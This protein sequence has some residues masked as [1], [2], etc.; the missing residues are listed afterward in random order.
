M[1]GTIKTIANIGIIIAVYYFTYYTVLG[2]LRPI[3]AP[4]DSW[5]YH[6]PIS[7]SII[8]GSFITLPHV[9]VLQ[10]YYPG[11]SEAIN[12]LLLLL[13]IPLTLSNILAIIVLYFCLYRLSRYFKLQKYFALLYATTFITLNAVVRWQNAVSIDIWIAVFFT[14]GILLLEN[15]KKSVLYFGKLGF[16]LGMLIGS[17]Y[18][19]IFYLLIYLIFYSKSLLKYINFKRALAFIIPF[20]IFGVFWYVRNYFLKGNP[21]Y[22]LPFLGFKGVLIFSDTVWNQ[23]MHNPLLLLNAAFSEYH[24]W[25]FTVIVAFFIVI[26]HFVNQ[27][28]LKLES[29]TRLF[30]IGIINFF[31]FFTFP[32]DTQPW[33]MVSSFRYS[34]PVFIPLI[35][36]TFM[37]IARFK[38]EEWLGYFAIANMLSVLTMT[39]YPKLILFYF[40]LSLFII[41][42]MN[43][44]FSLS[45]K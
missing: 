17:K 37:L 14:L 28:N 43:K 18:T 16:V 33:I 24:L 42:V 36:G 10:R 8:N 22:P 38:K 15:P 25:I 23:M 39:Y 3:P 2:I 20:S 1:K 31:I 29:E 13:H 7:Q 27:K 19:A 45:K 35:L 30:L 41:Y 6:I 4:G 32:T 9:I 5:D 12:S 11:S 44:K 40:P 34:Y 26:K 21:F